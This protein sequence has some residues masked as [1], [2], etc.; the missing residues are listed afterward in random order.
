MESQFMDGSLLAAALRYAEMGYHVFRLAPMAKVPIRHSRGFLEAT[1]HEAII[2]S[3][4][5]EQPQANIGIATAGLMVI[6]IDPGATWQ[7]ESDNAHLLAMAG[8]IQRT[9]RDGKHYV[10]RRPEGRWRPWRISASALG[11]KVDTRTDGGYICGAPALLATGRYS[12]ELAL[13][14]RDE[15]PI[16]PELLGAMLDEVEKNRQHKIQP[17]ASQPLLPQSDIIPMAGRGHTCSRRSC[18]D[19]SQQRRLIRQQSSRDRATRP[20]FRLV[21]PCAQ[22][23]QIGRPSSGNCTSTIEIAVGRC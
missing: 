5:T 4:W 17:A 13:P 19:A 23:A 9:P 21:H 18:L 10:F 11:A 20:Y 2:R 8:A 12:W 1:T 22:L 16:V 14:M 7:D 6:D 3:W 15:L